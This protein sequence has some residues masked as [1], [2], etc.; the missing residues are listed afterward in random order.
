[1]ARITIFKV[2]YHF[3]EPMEELRAENK[4]LKA[5]IKGLEYENKMYKQLLDNLFMHRT[6]WPSTFGKPSR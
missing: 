3:Q 4:A 1:M 6:N 2:F 5:K